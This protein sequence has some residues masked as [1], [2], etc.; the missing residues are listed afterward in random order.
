MEEDD[1]GIEMLLD[2][3]KKSKFHSVRKVAL[4][5]IEDMAEAAPV[6]ILGQILDLEKDPEMR[7]LIVRTLGE[8]ESDEAVPFLLKVGLEDKDKKVRM[9]VISALEEIGTSKAREA[10]M[11]IIEK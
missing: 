3:Y 6:N 2:I 1:P 9:E 8:T 7:R 5:A 10:L 4:Y 11:K